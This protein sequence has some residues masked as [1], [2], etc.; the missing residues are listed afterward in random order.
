V[1]KLSLWILVVMTLVHVTVITLALVVGVGV[2]SKEI[3]FTA[4]EDDVLVLMDVYRYLTIKQNIEDKIDNVEWDDENLLIQTEQ[5]LY[6]W[7]HGKFYEYGNLKD[8]Q[9]YLLWSPDHKKLAYSLLTETGDFPSLD[10]YITVQNKELTIAESSLDEF[11]IAWSP[12]ST[13]LAYIVYSDGAYYVE[14]INLES[15][16]KLF[17]QAAHIDSLGWSYN[18]RYITYQGESENEE[19]IFVFDYLTEEN[20]LLFAEN[21][22]A[23]NPAWSP[24]DYRI[25]YASTEIHITDIT[26]KNT[27]RISDPQVDAFYPVW[28]L[29]GKSIVYF[30]HPNTRSLYYIPDVENPQSQLLYENVGSVVPVWRPTGQ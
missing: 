18:S 2:P 28:S 9:S 11:P 23:S 12:D 5:R 10:L 8:G 30:V 1:A 29:D 26:G 6:E 3:V 19:G 15:M 14:I 25:A 21:T 13:A 17:I 7:R 27:S 4:G 24:T 16:E 22:S 20:R